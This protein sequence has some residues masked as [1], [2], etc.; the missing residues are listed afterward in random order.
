MHGRVKTRTTAEEQ[1]LK[2]KERAK[3]IKLYKEGIGLLFE[4]RK[5]GEKDE[6]ALEVSAQL[7]SANPD[8]NTLWN[9]RKEIILHLKEIWTIDDLC[10][11]MEGELRLTES[12]LRT[13]PKSYGTWHHRC[14]ILDNMPEPNWQKEL[15][16]CNKYLDLDERN[17]HCWD[18]RRFVAERAGVEPTDELDYTDEKISSNFSNY[19]AW[20]Y[21]SKLLPS[22]YPDPQGVRPIQEEKHK[23]ELEL[24]QSA[25]FTDPNDQSAWFY[26]RWL[27]GREIQ[28][29][30]IIHVG[31]CKNIICI[32]FN[33]SVN[34]KSKGI[35]V[36]G[37]DSETSEWTAA[38]NEPTSYVWTKT[39]PT[40]N[41]TQRINLQLKVSSNIS[42]EV[43]LDWEN[44]KTEMWFSTQPQFQADF[45]PGLIAVLKEV[46]ISCDQLLA[47]EPDSKWTLLTSLLLMQAV[48]RDKYKEETM[49]R[50][51]SLITVDK[52]RGNY[53][54][55]L[56]SRYVMEYLLDTWN[57]KDVFSASNCGLTA[58][59]HSQHLLAAKQVNLSG[60]SLQRSLPLLY[61]LQFC[62]LLV[63]DDNNLHSLRGF[64]SLPNLH[65][66]SL[67]NNQLK[68][69][70]DILPYIATCTSL[71]HVY[72]DNNPL[73][74]CTSNDDDSLDKICDL[75]LLKIA[76]K[77]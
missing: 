7:L 18:Y 12:C 28:E 42:Q 32:A 75:A 76:D 14:W 5:K 43:T 45:S 13:Q 77:L 46:L 38:N 1:E 24:V 50:L 37:I 56:K 21:R 49:K 53:Y 51:S 36:L 8:I 65:T 70:D 10:Q 22:V 58:L 6:N 44:S 11:M 33:Q 29:L 74:S 68:C 19:S 34:P 71:V 69:A 73:V 35:E 61:P 2:K 30:R 41:N 9:I 66:L 40:G 62:Q 67:K 23:E 72:V 27:L 26:Q 64:R 54:R 63:L 47:L 16:L 4:K 20:H 60:N 55:D 31:V 15:S 48:D 25:A 39:L 52:L 17:F 3:K 59:Y 57:N